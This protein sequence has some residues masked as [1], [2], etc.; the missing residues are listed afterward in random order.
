MNLF[1]VINFD[2]YKNRYENLDFEI[3][4]EFLTIV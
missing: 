2:D 3:L 4:P 1:N